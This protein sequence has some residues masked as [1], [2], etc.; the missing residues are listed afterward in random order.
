M[1]DRSPVIV[2]VIVKEEEYFGIYSEQNNKLSFNEKLSALNG[3]IVIKNIDDNGDVSISYMFS[4]DYL[5]RYFLVSKS[6]P[7]TIEDFVLVD[8]K[9]T[10]V[11][12]IISLNF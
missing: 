3:K 8:N 1:M 7:I 9:E 2:K 11:R 6:N 10:Y 5:P 12:I 4:C